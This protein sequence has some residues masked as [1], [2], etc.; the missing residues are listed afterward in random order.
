MNTDQ[1]LATIRVLREFDRYLLNQHRETER[2]HLFARSGLFE[3]VVTLDD[4]R[5]VNVLS[6][7]REAI[8]A[9]HKTIQGLWYRMA[10]AA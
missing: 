2:Q 3:R 8:W 5:Q 7:K 4:V 6:K 10:F 9:A 1:R